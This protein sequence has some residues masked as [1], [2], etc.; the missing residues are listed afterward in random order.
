MEKFK[1]LTLVGNQLG[2]IEFDIDS[3]LHR[4]MLKEGRVVEGT[5]GLH[6]FKE[7]IGNTPIWFRLQE[8]ETPFIND[9]DYDL[10]KNLI[11]ESKK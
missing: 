7:E 5:D 4:T 10:V 2:R 1:V 8:D 9:S 3:E 6:F 11:E